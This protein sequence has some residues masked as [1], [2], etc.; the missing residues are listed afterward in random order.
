MACNSLP[1]GY[2]EKKMNAFKKMNARF[3]ERLG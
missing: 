1:G 3:N 2:F